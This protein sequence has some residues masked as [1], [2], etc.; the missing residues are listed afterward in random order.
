MSKE[1]VLNGLLPGGKHRDLAEYLVC[2]YRRELRSE[3]LSDDKRTE[4]GV[5]QSGYRSDNER[6]GNYGRISKPVF[7]R[8]LQRRCGAVCR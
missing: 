6:R 7:H 4:C 1:L 8:A 3:S 5:V 2:P